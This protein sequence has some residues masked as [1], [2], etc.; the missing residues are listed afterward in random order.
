MSDPTQAGASELAAQVRERFESFQQSARTI[1]KF[2]SDTEKSVTE[3]I[4]RNADLLT[5]LTPIEGNEEKNLA[6]DAGDDDAN[7]H[8]VELDDETAAYLAK[9]M[10]EH[11]VTLERY[12][13]ILFEM[14][15]I[16]F[17]AAFEAYLRDVI[18]ATLRHRPQILKS[19]KQMSVEKIIDLQERGNLVAFL[20]ERE[21]NELSYRSFRDQADY[22]REKFKLEIA[23]MADLDELVEY[24]ARRNLYVHN[25]GF[26]NSRYLDAV[27]DSA[28]AIGERL[29]MT[30]EYWTEAHTALSRVAMHVRDHLIRKYSLKV[31]RSGA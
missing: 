17:V 31:R 24:H 4:A 21:V 28:A 13:T 8:A 20:A 10:S 11:A 3:L 15:F 6:E 16:Y 9:L 19:G 7:D 12:P 14:A 1:T 30:Q 22:Y 26:V 2:V 25:G 27:T 5:R 29:E 18:E 23:A